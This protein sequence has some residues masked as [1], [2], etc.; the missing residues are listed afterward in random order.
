MI[1]KTFTTCLAHTLTI[2]FSPGRLSMVG[3]LETMD[4]DLAY[5]RSRF[6]SALAPLLSDPRKVNSVS[7][8]GD[9]YRVFLA[10]LSREQKDLVCQMYQEDFAMFGYDCDMP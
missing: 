6:P 7:G 1:M 3:K 9:D 4:H 5:L 8:A 10:Q 2:P